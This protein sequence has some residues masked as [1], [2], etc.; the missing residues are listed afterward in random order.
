MFGPG[1]LD[2]TQENGFKVWSNTKYI[3][4]CQHDT[5]TR[6]GF[7]FQPIVSLGLSRVTGPCL[8]QPDSENACKST[9]TKIY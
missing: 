4:P 3:G 6:L 9:T 8:G 7:D 1:C 5:S 2:T